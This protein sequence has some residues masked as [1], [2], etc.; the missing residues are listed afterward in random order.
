MMVELDIIEKD[1]LV[2]KEE[3]EPKWAELASNFLKDRL[4][5]IRHAYKIGNDKIKEIVFNSFDANKDG[6]LNLTELAGVQ[7]WVLCGRKNCVAG[8][9]A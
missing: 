4:E 2:S 9:K 1:G 5:K 8:K 6:K 3:F 7:N